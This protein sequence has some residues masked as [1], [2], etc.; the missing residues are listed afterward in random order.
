MTPQQAYEFLISA[1]NYCMVFSF[2][3]AGPWEAA[4]KLDRIALRL[5]ADGVQVDIEHTLGN[6]NR[7]QHIRELAGYKP[8]SLKP[9]AA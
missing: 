1:A 9:E 5:C 8:L 4:A 7:W 6:L 2:D 3:D